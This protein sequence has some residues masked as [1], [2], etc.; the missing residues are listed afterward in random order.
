MKNYVS[1]S[2]GKLRFIDSCQFMQTSRDARVKASS[3]DTL[4]VKRQ[5]EADERKRELLLGNGV[6][7]Y[8]YMDS[9]DRFE[10]AA[11]LKQSAFYR[12]LKGEHIEDK[13]YKHAQK[14]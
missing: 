8:E 5:F 11:L 10:K 9:W 12:K 7:P 3:P 2:F 4:K 14:V 6:Y 1:F 13:D